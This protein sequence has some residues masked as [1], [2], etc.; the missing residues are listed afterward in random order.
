M[1][2]LSNLVIT[3]SSFLSRRA[4]GVE[5]QPYLSGSAR[6]DDAK[7]FVLVETMLSQMI[8]EDGE[9]IRCEETP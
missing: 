1:I 4:E 2:P 6:K 3:L 7:S 9:K 8:H 5:E